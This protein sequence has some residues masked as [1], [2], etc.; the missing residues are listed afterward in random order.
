[1]NIVTLYITHKNKE[2]AKKVSDHLLPQRLVACTNFF[3]IQSSYWWKGNIE[4][5]DE[6]VTLFKTT[7]ESLEKT[8]AEIIKIH[9]YDTPCILVNEVVA[10]ESYGIW[11]YNEIKL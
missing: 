9:P 7:K 6:I 11:I 5:A 8:K 1:M 10:N 4:E 2:E 3:P